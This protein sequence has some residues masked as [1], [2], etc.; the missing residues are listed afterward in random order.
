MPYV[1]VHFPH[2]CPYSTVL[3]MFQTPTN[4]RNVCPCLTRLSMPYMPV[5]ALHV[6]S[7]LT[8]LSMSHTHVLI[9]QSCQ[10]PRRQPMPETPVHISHVCQCR[11]RRLCMSHKVFVLFPRACPCLTCL[12]FL[13]FFHTPSHVPHVYSFPTLTMSCTS[14]EL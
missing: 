2:S 9:P 11:T 5:H 4:A 13:S 8:R 6:C 3:S 12:F 7:C 1:P 14:A 10:C